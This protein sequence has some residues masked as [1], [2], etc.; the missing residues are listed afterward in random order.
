M[1]SIYDKLKK[2]KNLGQYL[3]TEKK[4]VEYISTNVLSLN[5]LFSGKVRGGVAKG[6]MNMFSADS[7]L[8][9]S[10][11]GLSI[12]KEAQ[13]MGM[14]CVVIDAEKSFD[15]D[16]A[17]NIGI[18]VDPKVLPVIKSANIIEL[19][20]IL[21]VIASDK[22]LEEKQNTFVLFDSWGPL[23]S[24]VILDKAEKGSD[25][26][27]MSL[28][29]W[30]NELANIMRSTDMTYFVINH[31][32]DN[33][34][35]FGDPKLIPGGKRLYFNCQN[36]VLGASKAKDKDSTGDINGAIVSALTQKGRDSLEKAKLKYRI[37]H[38]GGLDAFYGL[39]PDALEHGCVTKP[40]NG[41]YTRPSIEGDKKWREKDIYCADFWVDLFRSTDFELYLDNKYTYS[42]K[43]DI[44]EQST[45]ELLDEIKTVEV[46][47]DELQD[48]LDLL[49]EDT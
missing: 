42:G 41:F 22:T 27:D 23:V 7:S 1:A 20:Q 47:S 8:G 18:N 2:H 25:T 14:D 16:W 6:T 3:V 29:G 32:Y 33:T 45:L 40:S 43:I 46:V 30:K 4:K 19:K 10:F 44:A 17:E 12:L 5:L 26:K 36:I 34:G 39:L 35:G 15:A 37:K 9:K 38:E 49:E 28:P 24:Q 31:V 11:V 13:K 21:S 48:T